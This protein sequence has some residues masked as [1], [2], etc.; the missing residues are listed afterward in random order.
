MSNDENDS[1]YRGILYNSVA[2][3]LA[4]AVPDSVRYRKPMD[5]TH[6]RVANEY[7]IQYLLSHG[8][9]LTEQT[10][11]KESSSYLIERHN[12]T[13]LARKLRLN[14]NQRLFP[15]LVEVLHKDKHVESTTQSSNE[16]GEQPIR[17]KSRG[18]PRIPDEILSSKSR[19]TSYVRD[20]KRILQSSDE[21][22]FTD[23]FSDEEPQMKENLKHR[24]KKEKPIFTILE[25]NEADQKRKKKAYGRLY[26]PKK[27]KE[28]KRKEFKMSDITNTN[29]DT[30]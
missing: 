2:E 7:V 4:K 16:I 20:D 17:Q 1:I 3:Q 22:I 13:W 19:E 18:L 28:P 9:E 25:E 8:M 14:Q 29:I 21:G 30:I 11:R 24:Q 15:Q 26:P 23:M 10:A 5:A 27:E 12:P 6:Y